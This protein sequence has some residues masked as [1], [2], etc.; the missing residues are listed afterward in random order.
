MKLFS[1]L[2]SCFLFLISYSQQNN[3]PLNREFS[4]NREIFR[5][6]I[7][8][9][10]DTFKSEK[11]TK[12]DFYLV[13]SSSCFKSIIFSSPQNKKL[14]A[15]SFFKKIKNKLIKENLIIFSDTADKFHLTIDPLF[16]V[17][18]GEDLED[19]SKSFYKNTRG[20]LIRGDIGTKFSFESSF[21]ENQAT[22]VKYIHDFN[23]TFLVVP[24]QGRWKRFKKDGYDFAMSSGYISYSPSKHFN[25]QVG[26]GKHFVGDGYRSLLLSDN[27]FNYP[28]ARITSTFGKIQ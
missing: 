18:Y 26:T 19:S 24:G 6:L 15:N 14:E 2:A 5:S 12:L 10:T 11:I 13:D 20:L 7:K 21:L 8:S 16:N 17:E 23:D 27:A 3:L 22:F 4:L 28:Y 1:F 25:F 9:R